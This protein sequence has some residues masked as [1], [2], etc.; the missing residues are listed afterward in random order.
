MLGLPRSQQVIRRILKP[1]KAAGPAMSFGELV[2]LGVGLKAATPVG[3]IASN[4]LRVV[5]KPN[6]VR[7]AS[8]RTATNQVH[9]E[10]LV[11]NTGDG[12][13]SP[14]VSLSV[15]QRNDQEQEEEEAERIV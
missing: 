2:P 7:R 12:N 5:R 1:E 4:S 13:H 10:H 14:C 6:S 9:R 15:V 3:L 11:A 8:V